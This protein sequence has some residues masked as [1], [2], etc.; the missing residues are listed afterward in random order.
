MKWPTWTGVGE[1]TYEQPDGTVV[2]PSKTA[3]DWLQLLIVPAVLAGAVTIYNQVQTNQADSR[4]AAGA[5]LANQDALFQSYLGQM[6]TLM[7]SKGLLTAKSGSSVSRAAGVITSGF[8]SALDGTRRGDLLR[9]LKYANLVKRRSPLISLADA[10]LVS[11]NLHLADLS[12]TNLSWAALH[13]A[14]L[15]NAYLSDTDLANA[16]LSDANLSGATLRNV[17]LTDANTRGTNFTGANIT[18]SRCPDGQ[19]SKTQWYGGPHN[20][21]SLACKADGF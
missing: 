19:R 6:S 7:I 4:Q 1:R 21:P 12:D 18:R 8:L 16:D 14:D 9:F 13:H 11:A 15:S 17:N 20:T 10:D 2:Q 3:W 5:A